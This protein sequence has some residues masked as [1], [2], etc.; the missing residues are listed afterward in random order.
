MTVPV[1]AAFSACSS[2]YG[3]G[4]PAPPV[5][6]AET[7]MALWTACAAPAP[8]TPTAIAVSASVPTRVSLVRLHR[9]RDAIEDARWYD[10]HDLFLK[11]SPASSPGANACR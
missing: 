2:T 5:A 1:V 9:Q 10:I 7:A 11:D 3:S 6:A 4:A 8:L